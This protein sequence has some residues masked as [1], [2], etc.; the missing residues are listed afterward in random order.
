MSTRSLSLPGVRLG[1]FGPTTLFSAGNGEEP[2]PEVPPCLREEVYVSAYMLCYTKKH[3]ALAHLVD[4][5]LRSQVLFNPFM[6]L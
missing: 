5:W 1:A 2:D 6:A 4:S 3:T